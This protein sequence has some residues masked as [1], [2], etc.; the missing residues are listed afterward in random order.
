M[1]RIFIV[2]I[3]ALVA[4]PAMAAQ[5]GPAQ[6]PIRADDGDE[7][8]NFTLPADLSAELSKLSGQIAV[9]NL[10][11]DVTLMQLYDLNCPF[12]REAAADVDALVKADKKLKLVFVPY[13]VLSIQSV[14]GALIE[15]GASK[16]A[17]PEQYF[18]FHRRIYMNRGTI[19]G[20]KTLQ[21]AKD[22][23]LDP[24][25]V[26]ALGNT[27]ESLNVLRTTADFGGKAKLVATPAYA[28]NGVV[29]LGHPGLRSLQ[30]IV[31]AVRA[32]GKVVC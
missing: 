5:F 22:A 1:K 30:K 31:A 3:L 2:L 27:E 6:F 17:T 23:G 25:K 21:A 13:A 20:P 24:Q 12:C 26:A 11:G 8:T 16:L 32:C 15:I 28:V 9:G 18:D 14:Q 29:I 7:I 19:D 4:V 10:N